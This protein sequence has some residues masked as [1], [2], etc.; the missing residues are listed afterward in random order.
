MEMFWECASEG[1]KREKKND[2]FFYRISCSSTNTT[3]AVCFFPTAF[4]ELSCADIFTLHPSPLVAAS[5]VSL[6]VDGNE[7]NVW[8]FNNTLK[9]MRASLPFPHSRI[10][11][12]TFQKQ[13]LNDVI[14]AGWHILRLPR[15]AMFIGDDGWGMCVYECA[16]CVEHTSEGSCWSFCLS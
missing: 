15:L 10:P 9:H 6:S 3:H 13:F 12:F 8:F 7:G 11:T 2:I 1:K 4:A 16:R 5:P 14:H